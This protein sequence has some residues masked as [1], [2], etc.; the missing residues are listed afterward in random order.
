MG[1]IGPE[2]QGERLAF[3]DR[4]KTASRLAEKINA[5]ES[6]AEQP[7]A[8]VFLC[9]AQCLRVLGELLAAQA[10]AERGMLIYPAQVDLMDELAHVHDALAL[11]YREVAKRYQLA[12]NKRL[13]KRLDDHVH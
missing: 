2:H 8:A 3:V 4:L 1:L 11:R 12:H 13:S 6:I 5:E 9:C 7:H 10:V